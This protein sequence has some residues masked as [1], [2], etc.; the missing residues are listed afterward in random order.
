MPRKKKD[1]ELEKYEDE[2]INIIEALSKAKDINE[3]AEIAGVSCETIYRYMQSDKYIIAEYKEFRRKQFRDISNKV[4][5]GAMKSVECL[6]SMLD[7]EEAPPNIKL[8]ICSKIIELYA[9]FRDLEGDINKD[10]YDQIEH[11][12]SDYSFNRSFSGL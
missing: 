3:A 12:E 11:E 6:I 4:T 1:P 9:K 2:I 7:D 8:Q 5:A 10:M